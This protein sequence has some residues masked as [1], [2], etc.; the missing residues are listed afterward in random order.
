MQ[1]VRLQIFGG[2]FSACVAKMVFLQII[3]N[4]R[5]ICLLK[6]IQNLKLQQVCQ[7]L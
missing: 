6:Q 4:Q 7:S 3:E 2:L 5:F 1:S